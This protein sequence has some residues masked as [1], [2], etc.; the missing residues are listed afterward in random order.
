[1]NVLKDASLTK[2]IATRANSAQFY[3]NMGMMLPNPDPILKAIGKDISTYRDLRSDPQIAGNIRRRKG[4]VKALKC[5]FNDDQARVGSAQVIADM[6]SPLNMDTII[7]EIL[8]ATLYGYQP[9]E[10]I[11]G[12]VGD[13]IVPVEVVGKPPEW[14]CF[15]T[16]NKLRLRTRESPVYG[17]LLPERKFLLCRQEATY[18]NPYGI[19]DLSL[20]FWA[21]TFKKGGFKFWVTFTEKYGSPW[22][23]GKH[24]RNTPEAESDDLLDK[25]ERMVQDAVAVIPDDSS[26]EVK[27]AAG[28]S[29]SADVYE[30]FLMFC[31]SEVNYALLGQNQSSEANSNR[32][33]SQSGLEV[34][35]DIRDSDK[36]LVEETIKTLIRWIWD[37][38]FNESKCPTFSMWEQESV[39]EVLAKRDKTLVDAGAKF[40]NAYFKRTYGLQEGDLVDDKKLIDGVKTASFAEGN[41]QEFKDQVALDEAIDGIAP[42]MLQGQSAAILKPVLDMIA[43]AAD[44]AEVFD[45][46][47]SIYPTMNDAKLEETLARMMFAAEV[48]GRLS[49]QDEQR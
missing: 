10:V 45:K 8:E 9:L 26:V 11:W 44:Y 31:R 20:C 41:L 47:A 30:R 2:Q 42:D 35:K 36:K 39:D 23:I 48:W 38:N 27:E 46:L 28:K 16:D 17:E 18:D 29:A 15:D 14:F 34:T 6:L 24:P 40:T 19:A 25:L 37:L 12:K 7:S 32:A 4:A 1:M 13:Y 21:T 49:V 43:G 33:S 5:G 22:L 3:Y